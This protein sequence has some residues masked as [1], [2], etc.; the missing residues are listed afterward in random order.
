MPL[1]LDS[2]RHGD[3]EQRGRILKR[4]KNRCR[5]C[6]VKLT[7]ETANLDHVK[8]WQSGGATLDKNLV[9]CCQDCNKAKGNE[10][11]A[12][13]L[14]KGQAEPKNKRPL[15]PSQRK[16]RREHKEEAGWASRSGPVIS[17]RPGIEARTG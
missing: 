8:P 4:D 10:W 7:N 16:W 3:T 12:P 17:I 15:N 2:Q 13:V 1:E 14:L 9:A 11:W 5:Y 6:R